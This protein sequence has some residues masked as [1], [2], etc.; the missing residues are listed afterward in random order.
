MG[1]SPLPVKRAETPSAIER[2][3]SADL[4]RPISACPADLGV[5]AGAP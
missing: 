4:A 1:S 3:S 2:T 5:V